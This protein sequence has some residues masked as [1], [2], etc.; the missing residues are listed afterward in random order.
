MPSEAGIITNLFVE[1]DQLHCH[2]ERALWLLQARPQQLDTNETTLY[3]GTGDFLSIP[4]KRII[5]TKYGYGGSNDKFAT[6]STQFGTFFIDSK[7]GH[8]FQYGSGLKEISQTGMEQ[9]FRKYL[10][11]KFTVQYK[12]LTGLDY[13]IRHTVDKNAVGYQSVFDPRFKRLI[14]HKKDYEIIKPQTFTFIGVGEEQPNPDV[15]NLY[16]QPSDEELYPDYIEWYYYDAIEEEWIK[17][18]LNNTK[19]FSNE[20]FTISFSC[21]V[22]TWL[23]FHSYQPNFMFNDRNKYYTYINNKDR[24]IWVHSERKYQNYYGKK[25]DHII[26]VTF[27]PQPGQEKI[28]E[29]VQYIANTYNYILK[30]SRFVSLENATFDRFELSNNNQSSDTR[31]LVVK[32]GAYDKLNLTPTQTMVDRTDNYW[33]F[34]RF[35]DMAINRT[36]QA[37]FTTDW[38][39]TSPYYD[40]YG[41]GYV[42]AV[43]N[44]SSIDLN[45]PYYQQARFRDKVAFL[46]MFFNPGEKNDYKI[47]TEVISILIKPSLR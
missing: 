21:D 26:E 11:L 14:V 33:R 9:W 44:P 40:L 22:N 27:N 13:D 3:I 43:V 1:Q 32:V 12:Q 31:S 25:Y 10:P 23:S 20:S 2:T 18:D 38:T 34:N 6:I 4:P 36:T 15:Y 16:A 42:D 37:L 29:S 24:E 30:D 5:S 8:V 41:Q 17:T 47:A 45:K 28:F 19:F 46:R 39:Y 7:A 35:R